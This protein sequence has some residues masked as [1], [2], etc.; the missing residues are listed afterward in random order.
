MA[1]YH[2]CGGVGDDRGNFTLK[3]EGDVTLTMKL[4]NKNGHPVSICA[5]C[6]RRSS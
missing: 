3:L 2:F 1:L 5:A 6:Q 4:E